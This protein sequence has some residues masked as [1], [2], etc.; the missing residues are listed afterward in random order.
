MSES[1]LALDS[2]AEDLRM[3]LQNRHSQKHLDTLMQRQIL[4]HKGMIGCVETQTMCRS[5]TSR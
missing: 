1:A 3:T 2:G 5:S 4:T